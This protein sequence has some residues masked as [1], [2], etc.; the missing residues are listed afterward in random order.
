MT[1]PATLHTVVDRLLGLDIRYA[2]G[3]HPLTGAWAPDLKLDTGHTL[4]DLMHAARPVLLDLTPDRR[5]HEA[6][7][8]WHDRVDVVAA[9]GDDSLAGLL[10][11]PD[12]YVAWAHDSGADG[13]VQA[14]ETWFGKAA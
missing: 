6:A 5:L 12:G 14:L 8:G 7:A 13:L 11:R 1:D 2:P 9:L 10:V 3:D 4:S